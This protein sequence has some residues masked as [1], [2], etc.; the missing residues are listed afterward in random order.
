[1]II[2][3][4]KT[5]LPRRPPFVQKHDSKIHQIWAVRNLIS[6][7]LATRGNSS[8]EL[9]ELATTKAVT[10]PEIPV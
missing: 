6:H 4:V 2:V 8:V 3:Q 1:M 9:S 7:K 10:C 5:P